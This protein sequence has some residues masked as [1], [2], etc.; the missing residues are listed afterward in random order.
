[1]SI[2][3]FPSKIWE[4]KCALYTENTVFKFFGS[5]H[6]FACLIINEDLKNVYAKGEP[7]TPR[8]VFWKVGPL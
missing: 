7:K 6:C 5:Q 2:L 8:I 1:M 4:K 3:I